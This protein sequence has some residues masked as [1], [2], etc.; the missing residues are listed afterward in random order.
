MEHNSLNCGNCGKLGHIFNQCKIPIMSL[1]I[2]AYTIDTNNQ[3]RFL[4]IRRKNTL[5]FMDFIRGK[6]S[7]NNKEYIINLFNEMTIYEKESILSSDFNKLWN[8][9]WSNHSGQYKTEEQNSKDKFYA[10]K[11]G[12]NTYDDIYTTFD[13]VRESTTNWKEAE[14]GFP[15]GRRNLY[16]KD[17]DCALREFFEETGYRT[18][19]IIENVQPF[20]EI[21]MG[22]DYRSYKHK[23]YLTF[24][25]NIIFE[26]LTLFDNN[27]VSKIEW[28]TLD[29]CLYDIRDY[30][31]EKKQIL[32]DINNCITFCSN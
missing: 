19:D 18:N 10:L 11:S 15:K 9:L 6:Y 32:K 16:E 20:E 28:K 25:K 13:L 2:V 7:L 23:Y 30:N 27:E 12:I 8:E 21:F 31:L 26:K 29:E 22:S 5:G 24:M 1:G 4:M 14:W 3:L 17:I